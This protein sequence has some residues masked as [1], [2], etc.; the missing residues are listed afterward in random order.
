MYDLD[1]L[2]WIWHNGD[3]HDG[4]TVSHRDGD[5]DNS[6]IENLMLEPPHFTMRKQQAI[7]SKVAGLRQALADGIPGDIGQDYF[8]I[9]EILEDLNAL[10]NMITDFTKVN[11]DENFGMIPDMRQMRESFWYGE[12]EFLW[13]VQ[14]GGPVKIGDRAGTTANDSAVK[15]GINSALFRRKDLVWVF[16][17]G[18]IPK[19]K[20]VVNIN[21]N[22]QDDRI[23]NL[24][25]QPKGTK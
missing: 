3:L 15:I 9:N 24:Q 13:R 11:T 5:K 21:G 8:E 6:M 1:L 10:K 19:D 12:G 22:I 7:I 4:F 18:D 17:N 25:L 2:V 20:M 14:N 23:Q 16:F